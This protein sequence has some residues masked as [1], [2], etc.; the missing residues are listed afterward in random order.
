MGVGDGVVEPVGARNRA[1]EEEQAR[2]RTSMAPGQRDGHEVPVLA[3]E[4]SDLAAVAASDRSVLD[5]PDGRRHELDHPEHAHELAQFLAA[6][7]A[8]LARAHD[9]TRAES[10]DD[11]DE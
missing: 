4:R 8:A 3:A 7:P 11:E 6:A 1:E 2:D 9:P 10:T 5:T